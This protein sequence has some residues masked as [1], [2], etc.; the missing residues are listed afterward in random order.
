M[1]L[2]LRFALSNL[3]GFDFTFELLDERSSA[4]DVFNQSLGLLRSSRDPRAEEY[5][6]LDLAFDLVF[7]LEGPTEA[8]NVAETR[9]FS[10]RVDAVALDDAAKDNRF[11]ALNHELGSEVAG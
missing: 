1:V 5:H 11:P 2:F 10:Q 4:F 3:F 6:Q 9:G 7:F 8:G